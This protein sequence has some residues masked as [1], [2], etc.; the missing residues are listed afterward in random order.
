M[1]LS[2]KRNKLIFE[3]EKICFDWYLWETCAKSVI[4]NSYIGVFIFS[5]LLANLLFI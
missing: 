5:S 1:E 4:L 2:R 3:V